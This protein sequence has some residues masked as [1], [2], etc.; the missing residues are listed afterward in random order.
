MKA[1]FIHCLYTPAVYTLHDTV[2]VACPKYYTV[3]SLSP[4]C[5]FP[6]AWCV[7]SVRSVSL[8]RARWTGQEVLRN[9]GNDRRGR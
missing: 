2:D 3:H 1:L 6:S 8:G 5:V 4:L 7:L 9:R